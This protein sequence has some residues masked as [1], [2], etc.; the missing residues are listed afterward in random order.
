MG[1]PSVVAAGEYIGG[2]F[3]RRVKLPRV[4][5]VD[6]APSPPMSRL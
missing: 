6:L 1:V 4:L 2:L 3:D 5:T